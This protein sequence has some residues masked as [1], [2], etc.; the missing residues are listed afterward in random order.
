MSNEEM[1]DLI[2]K[3]QQANAKEEAARRM[4][5]AQRRAEAE[6]KARQEAQRR[7]EQR[8]QDRDA[9]GRPLTDAEKEEAKLDPLGFAAKRDKRTAQ[10]KHADMNHA[11]GQQ[12]RA[13]REAADAFKNTAE[14]ARKMAEDLRRQA[15]PKPPPEPRCPK[16]ETFYDQGGEPRKR[17]QHVINC[18]RCD[19]RLQPG[20][21]TVF[22]VA[23]KWIGRCCET[24]PGPRKRNP[25]HRD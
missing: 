9:Y 24:V 3:Y 11:W 18:D 6:R 2:R 14:Q 12:E 16:P 17:N 20:E 21:G 23:G 1:W 19:R 5:E 7:Y 15:K 4:Y 22:Q 25:R 10:E 13:A 8:M